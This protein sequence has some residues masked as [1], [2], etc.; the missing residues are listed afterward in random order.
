MM[1][2]N[3]T[4]FNLVEGKRK[5]NRETEGEMFKK[6]TA[7]APSIAAPGLAGSTSSS[8]PVA[9]GGTEDLE[10]DIICHNDL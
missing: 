5:H 4:N 9:A 3:D 8:L 6:C 10:I 2:D 7:L 1:N